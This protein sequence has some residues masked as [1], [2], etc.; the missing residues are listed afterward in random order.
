MKL[1]LIWLAVM[2][3]TCGPLIAAVLYYARSV[4]LTEEQRKQ[5]EN[6]WRE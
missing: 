4:P 6:A 5:F 1:F 3:V 2:V